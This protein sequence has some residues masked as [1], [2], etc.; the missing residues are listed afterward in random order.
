MIVIEKNIPLPGLGEQISET[1]AKME[2]GDSFLL[3]SVG[4]TLRAT[5]YRKMKNAAPREF[6]TRAVDGGVRVWRTA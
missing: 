2:I 1:F 5:I 3:G 6:V 4:T